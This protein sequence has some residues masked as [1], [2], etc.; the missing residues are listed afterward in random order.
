MVR[1]EKMS[2]KYIFGSIV[3]AFA[4]AYVCDNI[5]ADQ[6]IFGGKISFMF[7]NY[8]FFSFFLT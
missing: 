3:G 8:M 6:K 5:I 4:I 7:P 2:T 1:W